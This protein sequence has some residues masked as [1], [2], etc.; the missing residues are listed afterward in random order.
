MAKKLRFYSATEMNQ[1][2]KFALNGKP[3]N[4]EM[5]ASFCKEHNRPTKSVMFKIYEERKKMKIVNPKSVVNKQ[6]NSPKADKTVA[7]VSKG[8]FKIPVNNWNMTTEDGQ[9][10]LVV[11]F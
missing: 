9:I 10:Y 11:K 6:V 7:K 8:E 3:L 5:V 1:I 4:E 2:K